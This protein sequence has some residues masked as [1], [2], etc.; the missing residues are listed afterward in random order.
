MQARTQ[1]QGGLPSAAAARAAA[2]LQAITQHPAPIVLRPH[3]QQPAA[4]SAAST[5]QHR[6]RLLQGH[7]SP[8]LQRRLGASESA[9]RAA[10]SQ[11]EQQAQIQGALAASQQGM[12]DST[13]PKVQPICLAAG[14][15]HELSISQRPA[16][17]ASHKWPAARVASPTSKA[18]AAQADR[19]PLQLEPS[20]PSASPG[21]SSQGEGCCPAG[22]AFCCVGGVVSSS[23][24]RQR[25]AHKERGA[26][27]VQLTCACAWQQLAEPPVQDQQAA[28]QAPP[29]GQPR[30]TPG[31]CEHMRQVGYVTMQ[32][33]TAQSEV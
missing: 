28:P 16:A 31:V 23:R 18:A 12:P 19:A 9:Q 21:T 30:V 32:L 4:Q 7:A 14:A 15:V 20:R 11:P 26:C 6:N 8:R 25:R 33:I 2:A 27:R 5:G 1:P 10:S 17:S 22:I 29:A 13:Q 24:C 3:S